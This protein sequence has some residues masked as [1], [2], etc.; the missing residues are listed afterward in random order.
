M[1]DNIYDVIIVGAGPAGSISA[2]YLAKNNLKVLIIDKAEFPRD[3]I[4]AGGITHKCLLQI[5]FD[6]SSVIEKEIT[7]IDILLKKAVKIENQYPK[8]VMHCTDRTNFDNLLLEKAKA[9]GAV[10]KG[11]TK[12]DNIEIKNDTV[13]V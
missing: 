7:K 9:E 1:N 6:I 3:K 8:T 5:P 12:V 4:C 13:H 10:F 2:Y 11:N